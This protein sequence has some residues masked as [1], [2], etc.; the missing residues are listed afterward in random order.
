MA[1]R[2][3]YCPRL[4]QLRAAL[5]PP[6]AAIAA[7]SSDEE[8]ETDYEHYADPRVYGGGI[9]SDPAAWGAV[10]AQP[11]MGRKVASL[12]IDINLNVLKKK[13]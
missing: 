3:H 6:R 2:T 8:S 7:G 5:A 1:Q 9:L 12:S 4:R 11:A 13:L 10:P